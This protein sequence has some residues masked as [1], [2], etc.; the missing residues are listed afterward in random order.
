[1]GKDKK[2]INTHCHS[3]MCDIDE[4]EINAIYENTTLN[5]GKSALHSH[6][7][8]N[9][10][11]DE[12]LEN[13]AFCN[14]DNGIEAKD[15]AE[16]VLNGARGEEN[17]T[18]NSR[19]KADSLLAHAQNTGD[20]FSYS[21]KDSECTG[22]ERKS[23][24]AVPVNGK[25][26][27]S[28]R[29]D[30]SDTLEDSYSHEYS[31]HNHSHGENSHTHSHR[32]SSHNHSHGLVGHDHSHESIEFVKHNKNKLRLTLVL[33]LTFGVGIAQIVV[34][35]YSGS[36]ALLA[37]SAH[38]FADSVG[39][40]FALGIAHVMTIPSNEK[41]TWGYARAE[42]LGALGQAIILSVI[43]VYIL[44]SAVGRIF[45]PTQIEAQSMGVMGLVGLLAN[46]ISILILMSS[47]N[48][49]MNMSAAFLEVLADT[50]GSVG[51]IV[52]ALFIYF[53]GIVVI[54][55]IVS[56]TIAIFIIFRAFSMGNKSIKILLESVPDGIDLQ[57]INEHVRSIDHVVGIHDVH[58]SMI[59]TGLYVLSAHIVVEEECFSDNHSREILDQVQ[60][61]LANHFNIPI[62]HVTIQLESPNHIVHEY[63]PC[64]K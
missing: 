52:A 18:E 56:S 51:V 37:D 13:L 9:V 60:H 10:R 30:H 59:A 45:D 22:E 6:K 23:D 32:V 58:V 40:L 44:I 38:M 33:L 24:V 55:V 42:I 25:H 12:N 64:N 1:M 57:S 62:K 54:D 48:E 15:E 34:S 2:V 31:S 61:C 14:S 19:G 27:L 16:L 29:F 8:S 21:S 11:D 3:K 47:R 4:H 50:L 35:F 26:H 28:A 17:T 46:A 49:N 36:L 5:K 39:L 43:S 53:K 20:D 7:T 41:H 63:D